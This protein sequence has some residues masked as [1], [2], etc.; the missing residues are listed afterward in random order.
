MIVARTF[1]FQAAHHLPR[2]P[3]KCHNLHGHTYRLEVICRGPVDPE[4]G[5]VVDFADL[6][7]LVR[8]HVLDRLDHSLLN[9]V[10]EN[11][12]AEHVAVWIWDRLSGIDLPLEEIRLHETQN[13]YV[14]YRGA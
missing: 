2:H 10:I 14:V 8:E 3:G 11:P 1:Q 12:T 7:A 5:M 6:K 13:C 9:D 4:S